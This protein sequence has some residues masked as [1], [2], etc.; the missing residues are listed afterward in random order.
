MGFS[1]PLDTNSPN[2]AASFYQIRER[3]RNEEVR[4]VLAPDWPGTMVTDRGKSYDAAE[5]SEMK[6]QKCCFH[7]LQSADKVLDGKPQAEREYAEKLKD[8]CKQAIE[9]SNEA[10]TTTN[11]V[12]DYR[13]QTAPVA[14]QIDNFFDRHSKN[15]DKLDDESR[16]LHQEL[17]RHHSKG[18]LFRFLADPKVPATNNLAE[19]EL[20]PEVIGRKVSGGS[21][22]WRG[23]RSREVMT[24]IVR[25]L[26]RRHPIEAVEAIHQAIRK[27]RIRHDTTRGRSTDVT[28]FTPQ[29]NA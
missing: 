8:L 15:L 5:L 20:R 13:K 25:T 24:T 6:Q 16:T 22:T 4:E 18:N 11:N 12:E 29:P 14:A 17:S 23:A 10:R 26:H 28:L 21:K 27:A 9:V 3:H 2:G 7:V 19:R 1:T